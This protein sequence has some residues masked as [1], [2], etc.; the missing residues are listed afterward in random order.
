MSSRHFSLASLSVLALAGCGG[1]GG[2]STG[3]MSLAITDAPVDGVDQVVVEFTGVTLKP[4]GGSAFDVVFDQL[5]SVDLK[6]LHSGNTEILLDGEIVPAGRYEWIRLA[7]NAEFDNVYDSYVIEEGGGQVELRV[8]SGANSG[9]K[10]VSGFTV[11]AGGESGFVIDWNLR[12]GLVQAPGQQGYKLQPALRITDLQDYGAISGTV[13]AELVSGVSCTSEPNTGEG[14]A[15][16]VFSGA[17]VAPD[18]IDGADPEPLTIAD[19]RFD[20]VSDSYAYVVPFLA[21]GAYTVAFTCQAADDMI[22]DE[23]NPGA[24]VDDAI[25]FTAGADATVVADQAT[26][27]NF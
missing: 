17:G 13:A 24:D 7:V 5:L 4:Q 10:L 21:P 25:V 9:L 14:N 15:V 20:D 27:V 19:V 6:T 26:T 3:S 16:Y 22:P 11:V 18:D 2:S 8:P 23:D 12:E 1:G